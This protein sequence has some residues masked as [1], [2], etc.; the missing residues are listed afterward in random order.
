MPLRDTVDVH[1]VHQSREASSRTSRRIDHAGDVTLTVVAAIVLLAC[2]LM[3]FWSKRIGTKRAAKRPRV[4]AEQARAEVMSV[5]AGG[6]DR[7]RIRAIKVLRE[8]TGLGLLEAHHT[9]TQW[10]Q[11]EGRR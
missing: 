9:V 11:A 6:A 2:V 7:D 5:A 4:P 1:H 10:L 3:A 8:R